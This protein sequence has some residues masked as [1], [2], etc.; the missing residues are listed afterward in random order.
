MSLF[1]EPLVA[2]PANPDPNSTPFTDGIEYIAFAK[3][4]S[5]ESNTVR[6]HPA[7]DL[8]YGYTLPACKDII[9][10]EKFY[11]KC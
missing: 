2:A 6:A 3:S 4:D 8:F 5:I 1:S 7:K 9:D 11:F 10:D